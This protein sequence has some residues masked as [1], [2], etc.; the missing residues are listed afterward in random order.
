MSKI[1]LHIEDGMIQGA[2]TDDPSVELIVFDFDWQ[3]DFD[4]VDKMRDHMT[5]SLRDLSVLGFE[6]VSPF[7]FDQ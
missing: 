7:D 3:G 6:M 1:I 5:T 2:H 4:A